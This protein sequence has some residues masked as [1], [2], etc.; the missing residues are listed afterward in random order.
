VVPL[1]HR[2]HIQCEVGAITNVSCLSKNSNKYQRLFHQSHIV[3]VLLLC[4]NFAGN[5]LLLQRVM[6]G[7]V[8]VGS[9][10][11]DVLNAG[12]AER[13]E[14]REDPL[15]VLNTL[16]GTNEGDLSTL[17][18]ILIK[19]NGRTCPAM[20]D[21][22]KLAHNAVSVGNATVEA[23]AT[24]WRERMRRIT[25]TDLRRQRRI[26][27]LMFMPSSTVILV[28][29]LTGKYHLVGTASQLFG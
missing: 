3:K 29:I 10:F 22:N 21:A 11:F 1:C 17:Y 15:A 25:D 18:F 2:R 26:S 8:Q 19:V 12:S 20:Q 27:I 28:R 23:E 14:E 9:C 6:D 24:R 13:L 16:G 5:H 4:S 7:L